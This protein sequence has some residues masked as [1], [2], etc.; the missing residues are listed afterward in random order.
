MAISLWDVEKPKEFPAP[1]VTRWGTWF[2]AVKYISNHYDVLKSFVDAEL[3]TDDTMA[4]VKLGRLFGLEFSKKDTTFI[5]EH[6]EKLI[7]TLE[8][9]E[10][11]DV[12]STEVY[13]KISDFYFWL[14]AQYDYHRNVSDEN[15]KTAQ[16]LYDVAVEK[17]KKYFIDGNQ[18]G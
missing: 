3:P 6:C 18:P 4:M 17:L 7:T 8:Y 12:R 15:Y 9:F 13:D 16:K 2:E 14:I 5:A 1:V 11:Q 10:R